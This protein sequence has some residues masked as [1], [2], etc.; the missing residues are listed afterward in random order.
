[1]SR[2]V[3]QGY[4][5]GTQYRDASCL[6]ARAYLHRRFS[7]SQTNWQRWIWNQ[8]NL[9][10]SGRIL[11][12]GCGPGGLWS[13]NLDRIS[14]DW[15]VVL[16]DFSPGILQQAWHKLGTSSF[17]F[18]YAVADV[19]FL[20][21]EDESFET[22]IANQVLYHVPDRDRALSEIRRVLQPGGRLYAA[23]LGH[24]YLREL[25]QLLARVGVDASELDAASE[26]GLENGAD[27]L[28]PYFEQI[29][30]HHNHDALVITESE[31]LVAYT[32]ST[33]CATALRP[34]LGEFS[35]LVENEIV[36]KGAIRMRKE[37]GLFEAI[38]PA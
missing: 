4:L 7:T 14:V 8:L 32:L 37:S 20:P 3:D 22:V 21:F 30:L 34:R 15:K 13:Q 36:A 16:A 5:A 2:L 10:S 12:V 1:M 6:G 9:P 25:R 28:A 11:D 23:T 17:P 19:Q 27:Q 18:A 38:K 24:H 26:F 35:C 33:S 29:K 31:P